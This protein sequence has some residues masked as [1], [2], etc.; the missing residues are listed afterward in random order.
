MAYDLEEQEQ[1]DNLKALWKK[2]GNLATWGLIIILAG[3]AGWTAWTARQ[4]GQTLHASQL[5]EE[6]QK[7]VVAK[8]NAKVQAVADD[9][10]SKFSGTSY[11]HMAALVAAKSA[12]D[13]NDLKL[14]KTQLQWVADNSKLEEYK[15]LAKIRLAGIALDEKA[16]DDGLKHL[17]GTFPAQFDADVLDAKG[18]IYVAQNKIEDARTAYKAALE[19]MSE[20]SPG[21]QALQMKLD[22]IGGATDTKVVSK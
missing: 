2:Y 22:V 19:K 7:F 9:L 1:L 6:M 5:Y 12:F 14:A 21:R 10:K 13:A 16:Y 11:A 4:A 17:A 18:D 15:A 8:D 3:Y 20:K